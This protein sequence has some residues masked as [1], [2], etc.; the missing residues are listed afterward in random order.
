MKI[1]AKFTLSDKLCQ[2]AIQERQ[3]IEEKGYRISPTSRYQK[4]QQSDAS[5]HTY[6]KYFGYEV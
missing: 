3:A 6:V 4:C 1:F 2:C 5:S